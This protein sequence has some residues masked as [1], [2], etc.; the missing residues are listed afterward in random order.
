MSFSDYKRMI[1]FFSCGIADKTP[2]VLENENTKALRDLAKENNV[3]P[4]VVYAFLKAKQNDENALK[5][6]NIKD[7][8]KEL[9]AAAMHETKRRYEIKKVLDAF[10]DAN[11]E[12]C[13]LKGDSLSEL[14]CKNALR[15]SGDTDIYAGEN[16]S[17]KKINKILESAGL[18]V[19]KRPPESH[20]AMAVGKDA[21][22]IEVHLS[23]HDEMFE[24]VWFFGKAKIKQSYIIKEAGG[25]SFKA[26]S[27]TD[28]FLFVTMHFIKHFLSAGAGIKQLADVCLYVLKK[29]DEIDCSRAYELLKELKYDKFFDTAL[30]IGADVLNVEKSKLRFINGYCEDDSLKDEIL[31]D[32]FCGGAFGHNEK[33]RNKFYEEYTKKRFETL[34]GKENYESYIKKTRS[35]AM[36]K[37][38]ILSSEELKKRYTY[39]KKSPLL[40]P[41]GHINHAAEIILNI[42]LGKR[43]VSQYRVKL[44][45]SA[46][47]TVK[48]RMELIEKLKMI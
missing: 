34:N 48:K 40:I 20:H 25:F 31:Y 14:Y 29:G 30:S 45:Q 7:L 24:K 18:S 10:K 23:L 19:L 15:M 26:L 39:V 28:E 12:A 13:I 32:C 16:I 43:K 9:F 17:E 4:A 21:G 22:L 27:P 38:M 41:A 6:E 44:P 42:V 1:Y 8:Q 36:L 5:D 33:E 47:D 11:E 37:R 3:L 2:V 46:N 35:K